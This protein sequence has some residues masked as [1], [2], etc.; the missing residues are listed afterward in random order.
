MI[1]WDETKRKKVIKDHGI[2][3][4]RIKD[5]FNDPF[6]VHLE[7]FQHSTEMELRF[8][9]I[10]MSARYGMVFAA[11][12]FTNDNGIHLITARGAENWMVKEY[13]KHRKRF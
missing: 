2:D 3:F 6:A 7:D 13:E 10:G 12:V 9:I 4:A 5:V 1:T 8:N 11:Y